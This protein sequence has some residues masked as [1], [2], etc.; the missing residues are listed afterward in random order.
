[1]QCGW[2]VTWIESLP[3]ELKSPLGAPG[4]DESERNIIQANDLVASPLD[5]AFNRRDDGILQVPFDIVKDHFELRAGRVGGLVVI[6]VLTRHI[7]HYNVQLGSP[8]GCSAL[9]FNVQELRLE[10]SLR[11]VGVTYTLD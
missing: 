4:I 8:R 9:A 10:L 1:M 5:Q 7:A 6:V 2:V 3:G 11:P